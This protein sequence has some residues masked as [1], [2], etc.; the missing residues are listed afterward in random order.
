MGPELLQSM[1][2]GDRVEI[3]LGRDRGDEHRF[4][5]GLAKRRN[6]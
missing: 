2:Q 6:E 4:Q 5:A 3:E 1:F